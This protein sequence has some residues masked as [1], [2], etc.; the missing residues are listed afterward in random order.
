[1]AETEKDSQ[2]MKDRT[3]LFVFVLLMIFALCQLLVNHRQLQLNR[4]QNEINQRV[5]ERFQADGQ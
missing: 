4:L 5:L 1:M 2:P 3:T